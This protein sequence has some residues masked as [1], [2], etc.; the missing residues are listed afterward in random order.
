MKKRSIRKYLVLAVM[1]VM[2]FAFMA[3]VFAVQNTYE[4]VVNT[5]STSAGR[6]YSLT[7]GALS[8]KFKMK[9][10]NQGVPTEYYTGLLAGNSYSGLV[11]NNTEYIKSMSLTSSGSK[12][13]GIN[14]TVSGTTIQGL[15]TTINTY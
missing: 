9:I 13:V 4:Y 5:T 2:S 11:A 7:A 8:G 12:Y 15:I 6:Y 3:T 14:R 10:V 1:V